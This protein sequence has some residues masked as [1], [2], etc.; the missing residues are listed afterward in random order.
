VLNTAN[1]TGGA[2][3]KQLGAKGREE[4]LDEFAGFGR[5]DTEDSKV[6]QATHAPGEKR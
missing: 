2:I 3:I 6:E 4:H 1:K 5:F